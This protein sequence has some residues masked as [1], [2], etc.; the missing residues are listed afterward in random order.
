MHVP[1]LIQTW[2]TERSEFFPSVQST[3]KT[4]LS[5][6]HQLDLLQSIT[7]TKWDNDVTNHIDVVYD[8]NEIELLSLIRPSEVYGK[9]QTRQRCDQ[10][11]GLVHIET[12]AELSGPI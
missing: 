8:E 10:S 3:P 9:N 5:Y 7:K 2:E 4:R 6:R 12:E 11:I 1:N